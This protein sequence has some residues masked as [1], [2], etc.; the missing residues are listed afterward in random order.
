MLEHLVG[1]VAYRILSTTTRVIWG[2]LSKTGLHYLAIGFFFDFLAHQGGERNDNV[3]LIAGFFLIAWIIGTI[4]RVASLFAH[5]RV[6]ILKDLF[7]KI[8]NGGFGKLEKGN[9]SKLKNTSSDPDGVI[10]A[11][12]KFNRFVVIPDNEIAHEAVIGGTSS[13]KTVNFMSTLLSFKGSMLVLDGKDGGEIRRKSEHTRKSKFGHTIKYFNPEDI[14]TFKFDP[15]EPFNSADISDYTDIADRMAVTMIEKSNTD[16]NSMWV[17]NARIL[18]SGIILYNVLDNKDFRDTMEFVQL[19]NVQ[20][21]VEIIKEAYDKD[22]ERFKQAYKKVAFFNGMA[23]ET[24]T[25]I[26]SN[27]MSKLSCFSSEKVL[28]SLSGRGEY[29]SPSDLENGK[30]TIYFN[31]SLEKASDQWKPL[32]KLFLNA[33]FDHF[34]KRGQRMAQIG[35]NPK[36]II[37]MLDEFPNY[38]YINNIDNQISLV[39]S[40]GVS[41]MLAFQSLAQLD[42]VYGKEIRKIIL[43][44][45]SYTV[46][47]KIKDTETAK[48]YSEMSGTFDKK[49]VSQSANSNQNNYGM[50]SGTGNGIN[51]SYEEKN[52]IK[53]E[54]FEFLP[55]HN[56]CVLFL[57]DG[58]RKCKKVLYYRDRKFTNL[59]N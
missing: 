3:E 44:N 13:G 46:V 37:F 31:V 18:L 51:T 23:D 59:L 38:G 45:V 48:I 52:L 29:I 54:E 9:Y 34:A 24:L 50:N 8:C 7:N 1:N 53:P 21:I 12:T 26:N 28:E 49:R 35:E 11:K 22:N 30:T 15:Y 40:G 42:K 2:F 27:M 32:C 16:K 33:F 25:G 55:E 43:D 10:L 58:V 47:L 41:I 36:K 5:Y 20:S 57:P 14:N 19:N 56:E 4:N 39:R 17:D 6:N